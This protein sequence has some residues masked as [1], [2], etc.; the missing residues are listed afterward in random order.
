LN[1]FYCGGYLWLVPGTLLLALWKPTRAVAAAVGL[2]FL[3]AGFIMADMVPPV[4]VRY[5]APFLPMVLILGFLWA[6]RWR[7]SYVGCVVFLLLV[8]PLQILG[9]TPVVHAAL[10]RLHLSGVLY[11]HPWYYER[12]PRLVWGVPCVRDPMPRP[13]VL[14][15]IP[16]GAKVGLVLVRAQDRQIFY[17]K[18]LGHHFQVVRLMPGPRLDLGDVRYVV[19]VAP[20]DWQL[21]PD[22]RLQPV[23]GGVGYTVPHPSFPETMVFPRVYV[24]LSGA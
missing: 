20:G 14:K 24:R 7:A 5:L 8:G 13:S 2:G 19:V 1:G 23:Q 3:G 18:Y 11:D 22:E 16:E 21:P 17:W 6:A 9:N 15:R 10:E 4:Y 12:Y